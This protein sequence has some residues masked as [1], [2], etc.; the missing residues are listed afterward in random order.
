MD[1]FSRPSVLDI[2]VACFLV[3]A[4][5]VFGGLKI[6]VSSAGDTCISVG[7]SGCASDRYWSMVV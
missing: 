6:E 2:E 7:D 1:G 5:D 3:L 4:L